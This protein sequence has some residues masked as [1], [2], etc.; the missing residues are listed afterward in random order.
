LNTFM[1]LFKTKCCGAEVVIYVA[2]Q[3]RASV[4]IT[5]E[6][7][8]YDED[9]WIKYSRSRGWVLLTEIPLRC[10]LKS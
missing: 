10:L 5:E 3:S 1:K 2:K 8:D 6:M 9:A 7:M 4:D